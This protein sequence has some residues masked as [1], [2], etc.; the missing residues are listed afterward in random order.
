MVIETSKTIVNDLQN[1]LS[2][3]RRRLGAALGRKRHL[4]GIARAGVNVT[5]N[6]GEV[7][8]EIQDI[9]QSI[10]ST[11]KRFIEAMQSWRQSA[12]AYDPPWRRAFAKRSRAR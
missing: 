7:D 2:F 11:N 5:Y 9:N 3:Y 8:R 4:E 10:T 1:D 6:I 12:I